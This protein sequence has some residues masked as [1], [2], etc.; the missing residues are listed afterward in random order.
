MKQVDEKKANRKFN[1]ILIIG[2][3]FTS[4]TIFGLANNPNNQDI[5]GR[6]EEEDPNFCQNHCRPNGKSC[7]FND[8]T[9]TDDPNLN[10]PCCEEIAKTGDPFAC[11]WPQRGYCTDNQ[12]GAIPE[13]VV[14][15]R[16]GGPRHSWCGLCQSHNCP[17]YGSAPQPTNPEPSEPF[18]IPPTSIPSVIPTAE[19]TLFIPTDIPTSMPSPIENIMPTVYTPPTLYIYPTMTPIPT[20]TPT[21]TPKMFKL[22]QIFP[23]REQMISSIDRVKSVLVRFLTSILP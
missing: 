3:V 17:G 23:S 14:R 8:T 1:A 13:G 12:C 9:R 4:L 21:P 16:C 11:P 20:N 2:I 18:N 7:D 6:A 19:P 22:P 5:R 10:D 15:Q